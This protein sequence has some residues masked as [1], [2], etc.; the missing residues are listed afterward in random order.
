M[1]SWVPHPKNQTPNAGAALETAVLCLLPQSHPK[2]ARHPWKQQGREERAE[3]PSR[4]PSHQGGFPPLPPP[5]PPLPPPPGMQKLTVSVPPDTLTQ[6]SK[7]QSHRPD[8]EKHRFFFFP[9]SCVIRAKKGGGR[10][11]NNT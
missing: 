9:H 8:L 11:F 7:E 5:P 1:L 2:P 3:F 10:G 4:S 6:R